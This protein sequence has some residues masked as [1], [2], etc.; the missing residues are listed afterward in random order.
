MTAGTADLLDMVNG[1]A[2]DAIYNI[3]IIGAAS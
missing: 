1:G 3:A 2:T